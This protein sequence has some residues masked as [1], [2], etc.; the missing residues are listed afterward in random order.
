MLADFS[1]PRLSNS[2]KIAVEKNHLEGQIL[3]SILVPSKKR[4]QRKKVF[5]QKKR[6]K[7]KLRVRSWWRVVVF[8]PVFLRIKTHK[9]TLTPFFR[10]TGL[11]LYR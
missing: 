9:I 5:H 6:P 7:L 2:M 10:K 1:I 3:Y 11:L 8:R 4:R